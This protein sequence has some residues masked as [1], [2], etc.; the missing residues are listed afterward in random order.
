MK[1][2]IL[3]LLFTLSAFGQL[4]ERDKADLLVPSS[5]ITN[6]GFESGVAGWTETGSGTLVSISGSNKLAGNLSARFDASALNDEMKSSVAVIPKGMYGKSC[7]LRINYI[8][9]DENLNARVVNDDDEVLREITLSTKTVYGPEP[10]YFA[11]PSEAD[12]LADADKGELYL[13]IYQATAS[14]AA[15]IDLDEIY[16][17]KFTGLGKVVQG[18]SPVLVNKNNGAQ[19]VPNAAYTVITMSQVLEDAG[20]HFDDANDWVLLPNDG[21]Y[22]FCAYVSTVSSP[23]AGGTD[24]Q[25]GFDINNGGY[26]IVERKPG[27]G[28]QG[29]KTYCVDY[30]ANAGDT[31]ALVFRQNSGASIDVFDGTQLSVKQIDTSEKNIF[32][33]L[34]TSGGYVEATYQTTDNSVV[35]IGTAN[36]TFLSGAPNANGSITSLGS[37]P[38]RVPCDGGNTPTGTTCSAGSEVIGISY[39]AHIAGPW[40][41]CM[42]FNSFI[43]IVVASSSMANLWTIS[44]WSEDLLSVQEEGNSHQMSFYATNTAGTSTIDSINTPVSLCS[45]FNLQAGTN[46]FL[47]TFRKQSNGTVSNNWILAESN[48]AGLGGPRN[49]RM[50]AR[51]I[52]VPSPAPVFVEFQESLKSRPQALPAPATQLKFKFARLTVNS[53]SNTCSI[54]QDQ[55]GQFT[56]PVHVGGGECNFDFT[57]DFFT[58]DPVCVCNA[59]GGNIGQECQVFSAS[60]TRVDLRVV[61]AVSNAVQDRQVDIVCYGL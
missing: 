44:R 42:E 40:E 46:T 50:S 33:T 60:T 6:S 45:V 23:A 58:I 8:G 14:D 49:I 25:W 36:N 39:D 28:E 18:M 27:T 24:W 41:V 30:K 13:E 43:N 21:V 31:V 48:F 47:L 22:Q 57:S 17:Q 53:L 2:F 20:G 61:N 34:E 16:L 35:D 7:E 55:L 26:F 4:K 54:A 52:A 32:S 37:I 38:V 51:P 59:R 1:Y 9:G 56:N 15:F 19:S 3:L 12:V 11:C 10:L 5:L 29:N